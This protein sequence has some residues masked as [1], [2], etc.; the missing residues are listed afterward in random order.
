MTSYADWVEE[1][2]GFTE[3]EFHQ[4]ENAEVNESGSCEGLS[5]A[6]GTDAVL[7]LVDCRSEMFALPIKSHHST[8]SSDQTVEHKF[9][10]DECNISTSPTFSD[11]VLEADGQ[12][13]GSTPA[14]LTA[15]GR[16]LDGVRCLYK[17]KSFSSYQDVVALVLYNT[18]VEKNTYECPGVYIFHPFSQLS[19]SGLY[20]LEQ[21]ATSA[22]SPDSSAYVKFV[23]DIGHLPAHQPSALRKALY[24]AHCMF[25]NLG[26]TNVKHKRIFVFTNDDDP[27]RGNALEY[28][29]CVAHSRSLTN[30]GVMIEVFGVGERVEG[31]GLPASAATTAAAVS[32]E[33][34]CGVGTPNGTPTVT[35][36]MAAESS[37][38]VHSF[39]SKDKGDFVD[40]IDNVAFPG[41]V[42]WKRLLYEVSGRKPYSGSLSTGELTFQ[43]G[44]YHINCHARTVGIGGTLGNSFDGFL[45]SVRRKIHP[46]R[47]FLNCGLFI[48]V[49]AGNGDVPRMAV[50]LYSLLLADTGESI[51]WMEAATKAPV[52]RRIL[53]KVKKTVSPPHRGDGEGFRHR[54]NRTGNQFEEGVVRNDDC[55]DGQGTVLN[56]DEVSCATEIGGITIFFTHTQRAKL[57]EVAAAGATHGLTI[58][59]FKRYEDVIQHK[60]IF[61]CS[62]FVYANLFEGGH[63]SL[64]L[65]VQLVRTLRTQG[66]V[67]I[68][69]YAKKHIPPR[70]VAL[71]PSPDSAA[72]RQQVIPE[73][74]L[75]AQGIGFYMV[76]LPYADGIFPVPDLAMLPSRIENLS[77][78][79]SPD[80]VSDKDIQLAT[81]VID[82]LSVRYD[83]LAVPNPWLQ[84]RR[85]VSEDLV[86]R[87]LVSPKAEGV[88]REPS[89]GASRSAIPLA[90]CK[91]PEIERASMSLPR[92]WTLP[93]KAVMARHATLFQDFNA[94]VLASSYNPE[95]L[96]AQPR[97]MTVVSRR[98]RAYGDTDDNMKDGTRSGNSA[99]ITHP[100]MQRKGY[101]HFQSEKKWGCCSAQE[102]RE[103]VRDA[104]DRNAWH[105]LT[106][107]QLKEYLKTV[108]HAMRYDSKK[109]AL[110]ESAKHAYFKGEG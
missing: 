86:L 68:A 98:P 99:P 34:G 75:P 84:L 24:A 106:V 8:A 15:F 47:P 51:G 71:V 77:P 14:Q 72:A 81:R 27:T 16:A 2:I 103:L 1:T 64:R 87:Q 85:H 91:G 83:I 26:T 23:R 100:R 89:L 3:E 102:I 46:Q 45:E 17:K 107:M 48:G 18:A 4:D 88:K 11:Q 33:S 44:S 20:E 60:H 82:A 7:C 22:V 31:R 6:Y 55:T 41:S 29:W 21:L 43:N 25:L 104:A 96:C 92:D 63:H 80:A 97:I 42:F 30:M 35:D 74:S 38:G 19:L 105:R 53:L 52:N 65:F 54:S 10:N 9:K 39:V 109:D 56:P 57:A 50:S 94:S 32:A 93:D 59:C 101:N 95:S 13:T 78:K 69:Q 76:P 28:D 90:P 49:N 66:K 79:L 70:L 67:G 37:M 61:H 108:G 73:T 58:V 36:G 5:Y 110:I 62:A 40:N 12:D